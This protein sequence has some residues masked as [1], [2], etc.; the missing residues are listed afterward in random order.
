MTSL[1]VRNGADAT[2]AVSRSRRDISVTVM[3]VSESVTVICVS[4][5]LSC[6]SVLL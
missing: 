3:C 4:E 2:G 5:S 1:C 6:V